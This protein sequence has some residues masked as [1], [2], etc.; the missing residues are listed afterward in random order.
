M[1]TL[2]ILVFL[3]VWFPI[4]R[5][6]GKEDAVRLRVA[7]LA[8]D[9]IARSGARM[10]KRAEHRLILRFPH[11][12]PTTRRLEKKARELE[13]IPGVQWVDKL[14]ALNMAVVHC[15]TPEA[16]TAMFEKL[17]QDPEVEQV[18]P[19]AVA[20]TRE[21]LRGSRNLS[22]RTETESLGPLP[23]VAFRTFANN[24]VSS[25]GY[26]PVK[27]DSTGV[28]GAETFELWYLAAED[29]YAFRSSGGLFLAASTKGVLMAADSRIRDSSKFAMGFN[30]DGTI[31]LQSYTGKFV[32]VGKKQQLYLSSRG[33][34]P[35]AMFWMENVGVPQERFPDDPLLKNQWGLHRYRGSDIDAPQAWANFTGERTSNNV[36]VAVIDTGIDYTHE[37]LKD[38]MWVN[39][40]EI[41]LN[42]IDDDNNGYIDDVYGVDFAN[43]DGDPMDDGMHGTHCA[44]TIGAAGNNALGITGLAWQGV[45]LMALKFMNGDGEGLVSD[46][47][48]SIDYA[49]SNGA[50]VMSNSWGVDSSDSALRV[51]IERAALAGALFTAAAGNDG[52]DNDQQ[53]SYPC[54]YNVSNLISVAAIEPSGQLAFFSNWGIT[55]V[56][57]AAPGMNIL[58][59]IM[60]NQYRRF[61]GT[62]MATPFVSGVAALVLLQRPNITAE[63]LKAVI[64]DSSL[65]TSNL[66]GK[67]TSGGL[68]NAW[69]ALKLA[70]TLEPPRPPVHGAQALSFTDKDTS[71]GSIGGILNITAAA[72]ESDIDF[73]NVYFVSNTGYHLALFAQVPPSGNLSI[74][75]EV[76]S[77]VIPATSIALVVVSSNA[78]G[79]QNANGDVVPRVDLVDYGVPKDGPK[80]ALWRA[81]TP[82]S[83][84][85]ITGSIVI[86]RAADERCI[87]SY[88]VYW[89]NGTNANSSQGSRGAFVGAIPAVG[90]HAATCTGRSCN[91]IK[92]TAIPKGLRIERGRYGPNELAKIDVTGPGSVVVRKFDSEADYDYLDV[93]W[94]RL[95]GTAEDGDLPFTLDLDEG[96]NTLTWVTDEGR[97]GRGWQIEVYQEQATA[98]LSV[99]SP[100]LAKGFEVVA[101]FGPSE[102][103]TG[104]FVAVNKA[105]VGETFVIKEDRATWKKPPFRTKEPVEE[106]KATST[107]KVLWEA[108][109]VFP[110]QSKVLGALTLHGLQP[111]GLVLEEPRLQAAITEALQTAFVPAN[112]D[113]SLRLLRLRAMPVLIEFEIASATDAIAALDSAEARLLLWRRGGERSASL[114]TALAAA[115]GAA[116]AEGL[117]VTIGPP[118]QIL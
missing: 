49:L 54:N 45:R 23:K 60:G 103:L 12:A 38:R 48:R 57:I 69:R 83:D 42:G 97:N 22:E 74:I 96:L 15:E 59:T 39:S 70:S 40:G 35:A 65:K 28:G 87:T 14:H 8:A 80:S 79:E 72:D 100:R 58:S 78:T 11:P 6:W 34:S 91:L 111:E 53:P 95:S 50:R 3:A 98:E 31:T 43:N 105:V 13:S 116:D 76:S 10:A 68:L 81:S 16:A 104:I 89:S 113:V 93:N 9:K 108:S 109:D 27:A 30:P 56:H 7:D 21:H 36:V 73:Y 33:A 61:N 24:Y 18:V 37:D 67:S 17:D 26:G 55:S 4:A 106:I 102:Q 115:F 66:A 47:V 25:D 86:S 29:V 99:N 88:N 101:A 62:S 63:Q 77:T 112:T 92:M 118:K 114:R 94:Y 110:S 20:R 85:N 32:S 52:I 71:V 82:A 5:G 90:F 41:P 44:G 51:A 1:G 117:Q 2:Q 64:L 19:D 75:A 84:G 107:G 46:A